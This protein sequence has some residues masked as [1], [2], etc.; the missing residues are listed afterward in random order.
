MMGNHE[1]YIFEDKSLNKARL[2]VLPSSDSHQPVLRPVVSDGRPSASTEGLL[3]PPLPWRRLLSAAGS[4]HLQSSGRRRRRV[5][6]QVLVKLLS[7]LMLRLRRRG[8][9]ETMK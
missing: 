4:L 2:S 6:D 7:M 8:S 1:L 9:E 3:A 5:H